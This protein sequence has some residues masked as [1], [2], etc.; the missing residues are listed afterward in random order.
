MLVYFS[1]PMTVARNATDGMVRNQENVG[2]YYLTVTMY[3]NSSLCR[4]WKTTARA[5]TPKLLIARFL[6]L[7]QEEV[8]F[9]TPYFEPYAT[10]PSN[11]EETVIAKLKLSALNVA[12]PQHPFQLLSIPENHWSR[13]LPWN[14]GEDPHQCPRLVRNSSSMLN[15]GEEYSSPISIVATPML[16]T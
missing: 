12:E 16:A 9:G 6:I 11:A 14:M 7:C 2:W 13:I 1:L 8:S 10:F 4:R 15:I 5:C 3:L